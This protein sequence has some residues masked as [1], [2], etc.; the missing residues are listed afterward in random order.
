[1]VI[2]IN[3]NLINFLFIKI[4]INNLISYNHST[5][6]DRRISFLFETI[7]SLLLISN[8]LLNKLIRY[9]NNK[10]RTI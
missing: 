8:V 3:F 9:K 4:D 6:Y 7:S 10:S 1:M 5:S 2:Y